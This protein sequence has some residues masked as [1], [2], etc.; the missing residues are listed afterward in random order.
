MSKYY[1]V[2]KNGQLM[3]TALKRNWEADEFEKYATH[4]YGDCYIR[5]LNEE[6]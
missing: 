3:E 1:I 2:Y 6:E 4:K 5:F